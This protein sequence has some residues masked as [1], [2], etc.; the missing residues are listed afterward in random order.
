MTDTTVFKLSRIYAKGWNTAS[1]MPA[2][3]YSELDPAK[4]AE[5]NPHA[6]EPE[7]SRWNDGFREAI[8]K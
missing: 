1:R 2:N 6:S 8:R 3:E 4:V 5:L 7:R